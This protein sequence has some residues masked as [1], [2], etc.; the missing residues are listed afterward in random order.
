MAAAKETP[1]TEKPVAETPKAEKVTAY[2]ITINNNPNFCGVG[3]G[4]VQF[5][6]GTARTTRA[7]L[8]AWFKERGEEVYK[9]EEV[10]E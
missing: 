2:I 6:N 7:R 5:A 1:K 10:T 3:A 4:G 9:V 8:A